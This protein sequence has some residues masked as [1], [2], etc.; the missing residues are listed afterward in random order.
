MNKTLTLLCLLVVAGATAQQPL[1]IPQ[2]VKKA[3]DNGTRSMDGKPGNKYWQNFGRYNISVTTMPPA[4]GVKGTETITYINNSPNTLTRLTI[5]LIVNIHSPGTARQGN[6]SADYLTTGIHIDKYTENGT[7]KPFGDPHGSTNF[8]VRL[9]KGVPSGDSVKLTFDWHYD[10]SEESG[11][12]G[13]LD[14]TSFFLGYFYPRVAVMDDV[15]GWDRMNFTD[16]Q[17]FYNDFNDYEVSVTVPKNFLVW[18]TGD[19]LNANEVLQTPYADKFK[20]SLTSDEVINVVTQKDLDTKNI[21]TQNTTNTWKWKATNVSD[22]AYCISDHYVWDAASVVVDKKT[23]RRSSTQAAF[24]DKA[25]NFHNQVKHI[26]HSLDWYSNNWPGVPY[27]FPKSTIIEG[28]ADMEYP[29]MA[30]D[31]RQD[32]DVMQR[33][34]AEHEVG[35]S[36]FPFYMGINEHRYGFMDEGWTTAFENMIGIV[37]LG[38]DRA[39]TFFKQFRVN[40][41][42]MNPTDETQVPII[43]PVNILSGP[44][45][46]HNEYGKPALAYLGLKDMLGDD[47]F[48]KCLHGFMDRWHGKHPIPWD[49]FNSFSDINGKDLSWYWNNWFFTSNYMDVAADKVEQT[50]T[51]YSITVKNIGGFAIP[52]DIV[53]EYADGTTE[54]LHQT[55]AMWEKNQQLVT[56]DIR[57]TKKISYLKLDG[58]IYVDANEKDNSWGT[59]KTKAAAIS[60]IDLSKY[61]GTYSSKQIPLKI[62]FSKDDNKLIAEP[63]GQDKV[64]L[65]STGKD[66]FSYVAVG[67]VFEFDTT[68][69]EMTLKQGGGTFLFT[70]DK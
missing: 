26:Q 53:M 29:M 54:T 24:N 32:D 43:T 63:S 23:G 40:G 62:T 68:K 50:K 49:M 67:A 7:E 64:T 42:A 17:E 19:L 22:M 52:L 47:Q 37:D 14:S 69:N 38:K 12:E 20:K 5:K 57:T 2:N 46:G 11:R 36:Y 59:S 39:N 10:L 28:F 48:R 13:K 55:A 8:G 6:A 60:N 61:M 4:K 34:I 35:H 3:F 51:G 66:T 30:N 21:T 1:F 44:A 56:I 9:N 31:S 15:N 45:M 41:W 25:V 16:A 70:K 33:F 18:G 65:E 27:P 58:G